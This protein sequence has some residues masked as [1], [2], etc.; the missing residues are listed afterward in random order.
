[1]GLG[2]NYTVRNSE[3]GPKLGLDKVLGPLPPGRLGILAT[4]ASQLLWPPKRRALSH[5]CSEP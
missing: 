3:G 5:L 4:Q 1:M 2:P